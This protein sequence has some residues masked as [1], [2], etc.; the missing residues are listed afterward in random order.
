MK[1]YTLLFFI[2]LSSVFML[3]GCVRQ[4]A[5]PIALPEVDEIEAIDITALD[6]SQASYSDKEWIEHFLS[7]L[8][9]AEATTKESVQDVP[10]VDTCGKIDI[11]NNGSITTVF[12]YA[13]GGKYCIE[14]PYQGIYETTVDID[15][16]AKGIE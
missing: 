13:D 9:Q 8:T 4:P 2:S 14:Q 1:K 6:G 5:N 10:N 16:L 15:T 7:V 11:S 12:Y 3:F